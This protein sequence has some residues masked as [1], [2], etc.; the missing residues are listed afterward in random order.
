MGIDETK[1]F[2]FF[3][4]KSKEF[5]NSNYID[6]NQTKE[7]QITKKKDSDV[8]KSSIYAIQSVSLSFKKGN[9]VQNETHFELFNKQINVQLSG[10]LQ[11]AEKWSKRINCFLK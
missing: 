2:V 1:K 11:F 3:H 8:S 6:L 10:E 7:C 5:S 4:K 9:D